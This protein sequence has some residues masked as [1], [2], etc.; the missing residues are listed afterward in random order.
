[1]NKTIIKMRPTSTN[2][3]I[4]EYNLWVKDILRWQNNSFN[5]NIVLMD[6]YNLLQSKQGKQTGDYS[7]NITRDLFLLGINTSKVNIVRQSHLPEIQELTTCLQN[8]GKLAND[9]WYEREIDGDNYSAPTIISFFSEIAITLVFSSDIIL[10]EEKGDVKKTEL[11]RNFI[12]KLNSNFG[13]NFKMP[14]PFLSS[15]PK[16]FGLNGDK[17]LNN[18]N[19]LLFSDSQNNLKKKIIAAKTDSDSIIKFDIKKKPQISNLINLY[20]LLIDETYDRIEN[21]FC[22]K[23]YAKFKNDLIKQL[24]K[25]LKSH[26]KNPVGKKV[27]KR[28]FLESHQKARH[29]L[30]KNIENI[31]KIIGVSYSKT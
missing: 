24:N 9:I 27:I 31:K 21:K 26:F 30:G 19:C 7:Y 1:M 18:E 20:Q 2:L 6:L 14:Q 29:E 12:S 17:E 8:S 28:I 13:A 10:I 15:R 3:R 16:L 11:M 22:G 5:I 4:D 25:F 23:K